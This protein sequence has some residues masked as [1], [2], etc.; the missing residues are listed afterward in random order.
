M[1]HILLSLSAE[2]DYI[3]V[4]NQTLS[5]DVGDVDGELRCVDITILDNIAFE[6]T[7]HFYVHIDSET[8]VVIH[9]EYAPVYIVDDDRKS[10]SSNDSWGYN[11]YS[12]LAI[13]LILCY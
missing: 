7:E 2:Q 11:F 6:K 3:A 10:C 8:E 13:S 5:F 1:V 12:Q 9:Q 4:N